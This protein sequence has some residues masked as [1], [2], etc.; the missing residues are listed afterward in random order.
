VVVREK[1]AAVFGNF[2]NEN[3]TSQ[4]HALRFVLE[5]G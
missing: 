4:F 2:I 1:T 5:D 3:G